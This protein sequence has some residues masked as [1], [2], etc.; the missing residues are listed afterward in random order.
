MLQYNRR[1]RD[2]LFSTLNSGLMFG[3]CLFIIMTTGFATVLWAKASDSSGAETNYFEQRYNER[4]MLNEDSEIIEIPRFE[5]SQLYIPIPSNTSG[6][7]P[8]SERRPSSRNLEMKRTPSNQNW[9]R[10]EEL[11]EMR[12]ERRRQRLE[13]QSSP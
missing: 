4:M 6:D 7:E 10:R 12:R 5:N 13:N 3:I 2:Y 8:S 1:M 11:R 9:E